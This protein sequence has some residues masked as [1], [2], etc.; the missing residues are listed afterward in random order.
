MLEQFRYLKEDLKR[1]K[2][3]SPKGYFYLLF[4][5]GI[6]ATVNYRVRRALYQVQI[7]VVK[8][9]LRII[10]FVLFKL[11]EIFLGVAI[12][13]QTAIGPGLYIGHTG[14]ILLHPNVKVGKNFNIG[15]CVTIGSRGDGHSGV[16]VIADNVYV[17]TGAK[18][19]GN[20]RI[21]SNVRIGANAV[22]LSDLP[23]NTTAVGVPASI[24]SI[25]SNDKIVIKV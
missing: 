18:I 25:R 14:V 24:V 4:E 16:P 21:G 19:I 7:P 20:I 2:V 5:L 13:S 12:S 6:W 8:Q 3:S 15:N 1:W 9:I 10:T 23:D 22:V 17:H 11:S